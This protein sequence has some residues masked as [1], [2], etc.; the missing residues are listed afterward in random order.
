MKPFNFVLD[1]DHTLIHSIDK[2]TLTQTQIKNFEN[3]FQKNAFKIN[4]ELQFGGK[5]KKYEHFIVLRS[6]VIGK[7]FQ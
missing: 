3:K 6:G 7:H 1:L 4:F 2:S 5:I